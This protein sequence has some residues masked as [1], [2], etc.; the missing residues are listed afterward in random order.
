[1]SVS[2]RPDPWMSVGAVL[3]LAVLLSLGFWQ[4]ER[5]KWKNA[6]IADVTA[7]MAEEPVALEQLLGPY[8]SAADLEEQVYRRVT[9]TGVFDHQKELHLFAQDSAGAPGYRVLTPLERPPFAPVLVDRGFVAVDRKAA[10]TRAD[11]LVSGPV[12]ITG[13][14]R[15]P[16]R[17]GPFTPA[18]DMRGNTWFALAPFD[19]VRSYVALLDLL[20]LV[21]EAE[22]D[23]SRSGIPKGGPVDVTFKNDH[24]G[25][26][27]TWFGLALTLVGVYA[28][29][30]YQTGRLRFNG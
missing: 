23:P 18:N 7:R 10:D 13:V 2:F 12:R 21:V 5:L 27:V 19:G 17:R 28:V 29:Y 24:L 26:A 9:V 6:L 8:E 4:V 16:K 30:H 15:R 25:Y 11:G 14:V 20:P 22:P 3:A 1:M